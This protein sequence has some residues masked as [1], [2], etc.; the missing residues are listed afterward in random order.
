M[1]Q[2]SPHAAGASDAL[3]SSLCCLITGIED[4]D[5]KRRLEA[6]LGGAG[7][8]IATTNEETGV[9]V[10]DSAA[11]S[12][13]NE[14]LLR[15]HAAEGT[16]VLLCDP[17]DGWAAI[18]PITA[19]LLVGL[20]LGLSP[21]RPSW[22]Y[23]SLRADRLLPLKAAYAVPRSTHGGGARSA[24]PRD[25]EQLFRGYVIVTHGQPRWRPKFGTLVRL[26][27]GEA[28]N[29]L[30]VQH[31]SLSDTCAHTVIVL[32][33]QGW[34]PPAGG[35]LLRA[36]ERGVPLVTSDWVKQCLVQ[37]RLLPLAG[38]PLPGV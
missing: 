24:Q 26:A 36:R 37:Q 10:V 27:G 13:V 15:R 30:P 28:R 31:H 9:V 32:L 22:V 18:K 38:Y 29:D 12:S 6:A 33:Q 20:A 19:K 1:A 35:L 23:D 3:F 25:T 5:E 8:K 14:Q 7:A 4:T 2:P 21:R 17:R 34:T 11:S 16:L